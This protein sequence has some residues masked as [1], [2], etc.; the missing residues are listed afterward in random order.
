MAIRIRIINGYTIAICAAISESK[1]G[2]IYLDDNAHH[3]LS[4]KF[5]VDW[6]SEGIIEKSLADEKLIPLI[7]QEQGGRLV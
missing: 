3:A 2:D 5:G 1:K 7:K 6:E 4:T